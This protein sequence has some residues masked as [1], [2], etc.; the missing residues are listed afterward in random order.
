MSKK[1]VK[2]KTEW[3]LRHRNRSG[4]Y[5]N[6]AFSVREMARLERRKL[7]YP[8]S[9]TVVRVEIRP[10]PMKKRNANAGRR[11]VKAAKK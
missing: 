9:W 6:V 8:N 10:A 5:W 4:V 11:L 2:Y 7:F 3:R 1:P